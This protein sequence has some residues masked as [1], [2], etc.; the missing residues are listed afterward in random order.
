MA[1]LGAE[2]GALIHDA[3]VSGEVDPRMAEANASAALE[4]FKSAFGERARDGR[5]LGAF[6]VERDS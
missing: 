1:A 2:L 3:A 4:A 6:V 5:L